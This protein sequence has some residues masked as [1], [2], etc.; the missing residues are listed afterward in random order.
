ME[1][2]KDNEGEIEKEEA[3]N[4][5]VLFSALRE[6]IADVLK[7]LE[8][9]KNE[10]NQKALDEDQV[11]KLK[12][13]LAFICTYVQ[14]SYSELEK[15]EDLMTAKGQEAENLLRSI[16]HDVD[17]N[18]ACKY[19]MYHVLANL[20]D[21][22]DHCISSH[23][24][25]KSSATMHEEQLNF[26]LL[27][28]HYLSKFHAEHKLP[29]VTQYEILQNVC[30]KMNDFHGLIVNGCV[31]HEIVEYVL[32][33]FQLMAERVGRFLWDDQ[34]DGNFR[35]FKLAHL[36]MKILPIELEVMHI[37]YTNLKASTSEEV[38]HFI[39]QLLQ[40]S[41]DILREYLIHLQEHMITVTT[42]STLGARNIHVMIEFLLIILSDMP[43]DFIHHDKL[44]DLL[45]LVG[46]LIKQVSTLVR[47]LEEKL[48]NKES[49]NETTLVSDLEEESRNKE[50]TDQTNHATLDLLEN[51]CNIR[52]FEIAKKR[53]RI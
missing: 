47:D 2:Q 17:N 31:E 42:P 49:T 26:L 6:N 16:L 27:N 38:G 40:T 20:R 24:R 34:I 30:G 7:F 21:N 36:L 25:C 52:Q 35:L 14:L 8:R 23:H 12:S 10:E 39:K 1:K 29:L 18:V 53:L 48:R 5:L 15:F 13:E 3:N 37:C 4:S 45:A 46:A 50:G 33:Q 32:P 43:K 51:I 44:F 22:I 19:D 11:E 41:P 28:L 9:L